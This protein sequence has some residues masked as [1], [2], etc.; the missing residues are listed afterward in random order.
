MRPCQHSPKT[1]ATPM[2]STLW[3]GRVK[4]PPEPLALN[5]HCSWSWVPR[6]RVRDRIC[7]GRGGESLRGGRGHLCRR[8]CR[9]RSLW[10]SGQGGLPA[11]PQCSP[12]LLPAVAFEQIVLS[13]GRR[14][15]SWRHLQGS[16]EN[17]FPHRFLPFALLSLKWSDRLVI[18]KF[19]VPFLKNVRKHE[20]EGPD[21]SGQMPY[22]TAAA[23]SVLQNGSVFECWLPYFLAVWFWV[24]YSHSGSQLLD[25]NVGIVVGLPSWENCA[26]W[27][28]ALSVFSSGLDP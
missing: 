16:S 8:W 3:P 26:D 1:K 17:Q 24:S 21:L 10:R 27:D 15:G 22:R 2:N 7:T 6:V 5:V 9:H 11:P 20:L 25:C 18:T 23:N 28:S 19:F 4:S 12:Q 14:T 13:A